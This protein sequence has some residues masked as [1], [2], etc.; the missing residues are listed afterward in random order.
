MSILVIGTCIAFLLVGIDQLALKTLM[1]NAMLSSR[2]FWR[3]FNLK[4]EIKV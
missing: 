4:F 1:K 3:I 2:S